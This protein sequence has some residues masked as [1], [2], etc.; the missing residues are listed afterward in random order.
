MIVT[1]DNQVHN[2][3][4]LVGTYAGVRRFSELSDKRIKEIVTGDPK[5]TR[6]LMLSY[7]GLIPQQSTERVHNDYDSFLAFFGK[8]LEI[9]GRLQD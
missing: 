7:N 2:L 5:P 3:Y 8:V 9:N 1:T 4:N 6:C